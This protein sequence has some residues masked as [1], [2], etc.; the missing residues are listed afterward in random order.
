[1]LNATGGKQQAP[2][3]GL[4]THRGWAGGGFRRALRRLAAAGMIRFVTPPHV[5]R[6]DTQDTLKELGGRVVGWDAPILLAGR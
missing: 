1:M 3:R 6:V 2:R 5:L 4:R